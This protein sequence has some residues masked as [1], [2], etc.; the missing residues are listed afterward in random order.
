MTC[1]SLLRRHALE[2][3]RLRSIG[4]IL[5]IQ[6]L[7]SS[8]DANERVRMGPAL[9]S[10][11]YDSIWG[12]HFH[13]LELVQHVCTAKAPSARTLGAN[14]L[15]AWGQQQQ[16]IES[17]QCSRTLSKRARYR[18]RPAARIERSLAARAR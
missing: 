6:R 10:I 2:Y 11:L 16:V 3:P 4:I 14:A 17:A 5:S 12:A 1:Q 15:S 7:H 18:F 8:A 13:L 9:V